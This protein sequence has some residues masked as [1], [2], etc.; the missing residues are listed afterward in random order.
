MAPFNSGFT[1]LF[2]TVVLIFPLQVTMVGDLKNGRTVHSLARLLTLYRVNLQYVSPDSLPMPENV[3]SYVHKRG[4][5]QVC[6]SLVF[7]N[8]SFINATFHR[9]SNFFLMGLMYLIL[10]TFQ[11]CKFGNSLSQWSVFL[12]HV[13]FVFQFTD[14]TLSMRPFPFAF[15]IQDQVFYIALFYATL[16]VV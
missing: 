11:Q 3:Q 15:I 10:Q 4:I 5:P 16:S 6:V 8:T 7:R 13:V 14:L 12:L 9:F 2:G 1:K